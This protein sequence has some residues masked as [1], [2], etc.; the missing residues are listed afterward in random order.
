MSDRRRRCQLGWIMTSKQ[1]SRAYLKAAVDILEKIQT[2]QPETEAAQ[3]IVGDFAERYPD[4][5][6]DLLWVQGTIDG[7]RDFDLLLR[8]RDG[9]TLS[10]SV[11]CHSDTPWPLRGAQL[12]S[13]R[14]I[15]IVNG[16]T[17]SVDK[18]V[19]R[20][21]AHLEGGGITTG[22]VGSALV[23]AEIERRKIHLNDEALQESV[24]EWRRQHGLWSADETEA[25]LSTN[26]LT[27]EMLERYVE[28]EAC[29]KELML[30][31]AAGKEE[32][33][34]QRHRGD[35]ER[36]DL[37]EVES[38]TEDGARCLLEEAQ[39]TNPGLLLNGIER[40]ALGTRFS[41]QSGLRRWLQ[42]KYVGLTLP[43]AA[44]EIAG[45]I[46]RGPRF[47]GLTC[48]GVTKTE[49]SESL[50]EDC[51]RSIFQDW[52]DEL[53]GRADVKWLWSVGQAIPA[54]SV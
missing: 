16:R 44:G 36:V 7:R 33:Y 49:F 40:A 38:V 27:L 19:A 21:E 32:A 9:T 48:L 24:D 43:L 11:A 53:R 20:L 42:G 17:V 47:V 6:A 52:I 1:E 18:V 3:R 14:D 37:F 10:L 31:V 45:P 4:I 15:L 50:R 5:R 51:R 25:W 13:D 39:D 54:R 23:E 8:R 29:R 46:G 12:W 28:H 2:S 30:Q 26:Y 41:Y 34:F 35:F 22:L